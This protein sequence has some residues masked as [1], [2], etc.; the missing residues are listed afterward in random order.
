MSYE[1]FSYEFVDMITS[2]YSNAA[3]VIMSEGDTLLHFY[4]AVTDTQNE[5]D[6]ELS[7]EL[8]SFQFH[9]KEQAAD[10]AKNIAAMSALDLI[11]VTGTQRY[12]HEDEAPTQ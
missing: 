4:L 9:T 3:I 12:L 7:Q 6:F 11:L 8:Q 2:P 5:N 10:F 1:N